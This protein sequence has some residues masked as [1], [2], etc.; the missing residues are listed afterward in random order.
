MPSDFQ[1]R[2]SGLGTAP[3]LLQ[4]IGRGIEKESLRINAEGKLSQAPHP[5]TLGSTLTHP[6]IT[7]DY[8]EALLEFITPVSHSVEESLQQ[9]DTIHRYVYSKLEGE[10]LWS[11]SMPCIVEGEDSIPI[12][13]YGSSNIAK[14]KTVYRHGLWHRYGRLMQTI[15]GIH[16]NFSMPEDYW[17]LA[18][19]QEQ[20]TSPRQDYITKRYFSLIRNFRRYSWLLLYLF[21]ASPAV[22]KSF[23]RDNSNHQLEAFEDNE[24]S[25]HKPYG[26]TL[27]MGDLGYQSSAQEDLSICYNL[28]DNYIETLRSAITTVH[29]GYEEIGVQADGKYR[30]LNTSLLQIENEFYSP[31]RPKRV[32][33]SGETAL[34]ALARGGIE[35]IEV[36]CIDVSPFTPLGI[37]AEQ[38]RFLDSFL[39]YCLLEDSPPCDEAEYKRMAD[40]QQLVVNQGREPGLMLSSNEGYTTL[41]DWANELLDKIGKTAGLLDQAHG[42]DN[43]QQAL[44]KQRAKVADPELT[45]SAQILKEM[46]Q[47]ELPYFQLAMEYTQEWANGF[48]NNSLEPSQQQALEQAALDSIAKQQEIEAA[49]TI[50]FEEFLA[51]YYQQY[52]QLAD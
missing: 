42:S 19:Q 3:E 52:Q 34:G 8:S 13:Q 4:R 24:K 26:T 51:N 16:Y 29:P 9:L 12:A 36:R 45:P 32:A 17:A 37:D 5:Q 28:L 30:Q 18:Q 50:S 46:R 2:L 27:R 41:T 44:N 35:Y 25:F 11:S 23:L 14:M 20:D 38:I 15:A 31:I 48:R 7:T 39:L 21:G 10:M 33:N 47:R 1:T 22:C 6:S 49:D 40:N 43:Y